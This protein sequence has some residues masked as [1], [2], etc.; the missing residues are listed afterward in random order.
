MKDLTMR[1]IASLSAA[2]ILATG[3]AIVRALATSGGC[4]A[5]GHLAGHSIRS[6]AD[7]CAARAHRRHLSHK[8]QHAPALQHG[9]AWQQQNSNAVTGQGLSQRNP[10]RGRLQ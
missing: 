10:A 2:A 9:A 5:G 6:A 8:R 4:T 3:L 7:S 1:A